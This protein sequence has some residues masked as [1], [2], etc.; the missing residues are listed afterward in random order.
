VEKAAG[1]GSG[2]V[3]LVIT[4][5]PGVSRNLTLERAG[6]CNDQADIQIRLARA[7]VRPG[8]GESLR[9]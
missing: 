3:E 2:R 5:L 6:S 7:G 8:F 1:T 9:F 4:E